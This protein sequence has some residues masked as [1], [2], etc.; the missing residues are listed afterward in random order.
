MRARSESLKIFVA[1]RVNVEYTFRGEGGSSLLLSFSS[2]KK[3]WVVVVHV[4]ARKERF[5]VPDSL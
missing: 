4:F 3:T 2:K 5:E 1:K